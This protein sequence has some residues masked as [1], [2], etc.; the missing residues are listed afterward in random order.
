M[1]KNK[2]AKK[3]RVASKYIDQYLGNLM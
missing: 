2:K 3:I 1:N